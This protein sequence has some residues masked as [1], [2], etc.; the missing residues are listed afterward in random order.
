MSSERDEKPPATVNLADLVQAQRET[1]AAVA[2]I[3]AAIKRIEFAQ[4]SQVS[5]MGFIVSGLES[6]AAFEQIRDERLTGLV[7]AIL[8][9]DQ[10]KPRGRGSSQ[11]SRKFTLLDN[12]IEIGPSTRKRVREWFA[13]QG[14]KAAAAIAI[15]LL[16]H[17]AIWLGLYRPAV[18]AA[19]GTHKTVAAPAATGVPSDR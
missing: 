7:M 12:S 6:R 1:A 5:S 15:L 18:E 13:D 9:P 2:R 10:K 16:I 11:D 4:K 19:Y 3:E 14:G 17:V 8:A